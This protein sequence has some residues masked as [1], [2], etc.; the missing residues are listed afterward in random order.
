MLVSMQG[1]ISRTHLALLQALA[2]ADHPPLVQVLLVVVED[3][4]RRRV[5]HVEHKLHADSV[6]HLRL[7][8]GGILALLARLHAQHTACRHHLCCVGAAAALRLCLAQVALQVVDA[9]ACD[10]AQAL[11][12]TLR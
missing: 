5:H 4:C 6:R 11:L 12:C 10:D 3:L 7:E 2:S 1:L 8:D 9:A